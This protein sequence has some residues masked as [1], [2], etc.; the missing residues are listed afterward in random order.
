MAVAERVLHFHHNH[1]LFRFMNI[2]IRLLLSLLKR[3]YMNVNGTRQMRTG[4]KIWDAT[5]NSVCG[6]EI[7]E[8]MMSR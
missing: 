7:N 5:L 8:N 4:N 2:C 3:Q 1:Y 6:I